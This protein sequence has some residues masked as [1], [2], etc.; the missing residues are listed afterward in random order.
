MR[1]G[2]INIAAPGPNHPW[3]R[4]QPGLI[5]CR[6]IFESSSRRD[7][8]FLVADVS[9]Y[10]R[11]PHAF[12]CTAMAIPAMWIHLGWLLLGRPFERVRLS[13]LVDGSGRPR[14]GLSRDRI[15]RFAVTINLILRVRPLPSVQVSRTIPGR[16]KRQII[17]MTRRR[18]RSNGSLAAA[19]ALSMPR[20]S[21]QILLDVLSVLPHLPIR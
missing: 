13:Y 17:D 8:T 2:R 5:A 3:V 4:N 7:K 16:S 10:I 21:D 9:S 20:Y 15:S 12:A 6:R 11:S 18:I 14:G 19:K 1:P